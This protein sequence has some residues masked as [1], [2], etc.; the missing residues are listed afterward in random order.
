MKVKTIQSVYFSQY[1]CNK[2]SSYF[3]PLQSFLL[4][5]SWLYVPNYYD[6][7]N[8]IL[9]LQRDLHA[10]DFALCEEYIFGTR[11]LLCAFPFLSERESRLRSM[12]GVSPQPACF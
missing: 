6:A 8:E 3:H 2:V 1:L 12:L 4:E 11:T 10:N 5:C 9:D 7:M